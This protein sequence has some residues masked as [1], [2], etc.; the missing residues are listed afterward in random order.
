MYKVILPIHILQHI[1]YIIVYC[2]IGETISGTVF[3]NFTTLRVNCE[4]KQILNYFNKQKAIEKSSKINEKKL[5]KRHLL[6]LHEC[7]SGK[8]NKFCKQKTEKKLKTNKQ[9]V[10]AK[11]KVLASIENNNE[12]LDISSCWC[13]LNCANSD[14][15][16]KPIENLKSSS[17]TVAETIKNTS[18]MTNGIGYIVSE[19][20]RNA[21]HQDRLI[22]GLTNAIKTLSNEP[23]DTMFCILAQPKAGDSAG[24]MQIILLEAFC[25]ENGIY[26]IKVDDMEKLTHLTGATKLESCVLL[27]RFKHIADATQPLKLKFFD[28]EERLTDHCEDYWDAQH[29]PIIRLPDE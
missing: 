4:I 10:Q 12:K 29:K 2:T 5:K 19:A 27:Q 17:L 16:I 9:T 26:L 23:D 3:W 11:V 22:V 21:R 1:T 28:L 25:Y 15:L 7:L 18:K 20:L 8:T 6:L 24:H 13:N 14:Y